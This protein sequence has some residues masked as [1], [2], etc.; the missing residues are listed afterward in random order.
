MNKL[1]IR[2]MMYFML[3]INIVACV[4]VVLVISE[5]SNTICLFQ[6]AKE[7][8]NSV[9]QVPGSPY[10]A[11]TAVF[12]LCFGFWGTF[13]ARQYMFQGNHP[14]IYMTLILDMVFSILLM[15][16]LDCNYNGF[17]LWLLANA[18][19][20]I[21]GKWK[22]LAVLAGIPFF[23]FS[24]YEVVSVYYPLFSIRS[25]ILFYSRSTQHLLFFV[26][27]ALSSLNFISFTVFCI[28]V[29]QE[30]KGIIDEINRL[31][32]Q[33][34][35]ANEE[36][37]E[38]ADI[39]EKMGETRERNR[40]A[41]EIHDTLGHVLTGISVG[42]DACIAIMESQPEA[43]RKQLKVIS[44]VAKDGMIEVRR[45]VS[46]LR[47]DSL[48]HITL[49]QSIRNMIE[50]TKKA[51]GVDIDFMYNLELHFNE[52]AENAIFRVIQESVTNSIRHGFATRISIVIARKGS[53]LEITVSDNG[54]GCKN[55]KNG[56]G[57]VHMR[58]RINMLHGSMEFV[59]NNGF[60]VRAVIPGYGEDVND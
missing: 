18:I 52:D 33:L 48:V 26:F 19:Y 24:S 16:V 43:A 51:T 49:E 41:R 50:K 45:S 23:M 27:Y 32:R 4:F 57:I 6:K 42:V 58:E 59:S 11:V 53:D 60:T 12:L 1:N 25:Y 14:A 21:E 38:Y 10:R 7:F 35:I 40:L 37:K 36:L 54:R 5:S 31:Y 20:Y 55:I 2:K 46:S 17:I 39:K 30:Q 22:Y 9:E 56:F 8:L 47:P 3:S 15:R 28:N 34:S 29:I 44:G 13:T